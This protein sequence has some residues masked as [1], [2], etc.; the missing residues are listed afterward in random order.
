ML[1]RCR[2]TAGCTTLSE[3]LTARCKKPLCRREER[4]K[5]LNSTLQNEPDRHEMSSRL[6]SKVFLRKLTPQCEGCHR[7]FWSGSES[8]QWQVK[9][10]KCGWIMASLPAKENIAA[11]IFMLTPSMCFSFGGTLSSAL[12]ILWTINFS[13]VVTSAVP[14]S[15][16]CMI[17]TLQAECN[18]FL[19]AHLFDTSAESL[20]EAHLAP[21][22]WSNGA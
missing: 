6:N 18:H 5:T 4:G 19:F 7:R 8:I 13:Q 10:S 2:S 14:K 17:K 9:V 22:K 11:N 20:T 12:Q 15:L 3:W 21:V 1:S 16:S